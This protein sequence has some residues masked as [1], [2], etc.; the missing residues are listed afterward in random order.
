MPRN[1]NTDPRLAP[2]QVT[3]R[4]PWIYKTQLDR[5]AFDQGVTV[6]TLVVEALEDAYPPEPLTAAAS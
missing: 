3:F 5:L 4:V 6:P 2:V 1:V